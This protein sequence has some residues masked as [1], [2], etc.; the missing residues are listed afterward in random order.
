MALHYRGFALGEVGKAA[1]Q[2]RLYIEK[3]MNL[4]GKSMA[5]KEGTV[6]IGHGHSQ[7]WRDLKDL[8]QDKLGLKPDEFNMQ[9]AAGITTKERLRECSMQL[10]SLSSL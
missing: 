5:R 9:P 4:K 3:R 2:T 7:A 6:F 1:K 8:L 10:Y